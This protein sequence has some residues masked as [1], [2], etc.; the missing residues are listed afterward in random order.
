M[1]GKLLFLILVDNKTNLNKVIYVMSVMYNLNSVIHATYNIAFYMIHL[2]IKNKT[3]QQG[4]QTG[5][6][7]D[8]KE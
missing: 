2:K 3:D 7:L 8:M 6:Q 5:R 4:L 1:N